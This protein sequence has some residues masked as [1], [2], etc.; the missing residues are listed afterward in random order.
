MR[1]CRYCGK[2]MRFDRFVKEISMSV[3]KSFGL[4]ATGAVLLAT[5]QKGC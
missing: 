3:Y 5:K 1:L 4:T 2:Q